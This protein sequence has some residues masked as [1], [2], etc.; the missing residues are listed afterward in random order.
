MCLTFLSPFSPIYS[1][2]DGPKKVQLGKNEYSVIQSDTM[3][4]QGVTCM[5]GIE[6]G[7]R[8]DDPKKLHYSE[9]QSDTKKKRRLNPRGGDRNRG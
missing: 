3:H 1:C 8:T 4:Q 9:I 7:G 2:F 6:I 5:V